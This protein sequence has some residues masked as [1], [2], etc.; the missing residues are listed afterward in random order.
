ML[1]VL[2]RFLLAV[3]LASFGRAADEPRPVR[4]IDPAAVLSA[5]AA[6][7]TNQYPDAD[8]VLVDAV[9]FERY[10]PDGT[11]TAW[12]EEAVKVLTEAGRRATRVQR[13]TSMSPT[14]PPPWPARTSTSRMAAARRSTSPGPAG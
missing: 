10:N 5:A 1:P 3:L 6:V 13:C 12:N 11:S 4:R 2:R 9:V 7:T 14:V 8:T